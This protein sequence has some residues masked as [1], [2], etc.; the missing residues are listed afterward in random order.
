MRP[1]QRVSCVIHRGA[2]QDLYIDRVIARHSREIIGIRSFHLCSRKTAPRTCVPLVSLSDTCCQ[3]TETLLPIGRLV[4][5]RDTTPYS[6]DTQAVN[7]CVASTKR[8]CSGHGRQ[9]HAIGVGWAKGV[10]KLNSM[11]SP[12]TSLN[13]HAERTPGKAD[14]HVGIVR[15]PP[16]HHATIH[17]LATHI[18]TMGSVSGQS[19]GTC[20]MS[21]PYPADADA[22]ARVILGAIRR[23]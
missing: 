12:L 4:L 7:Q 23:Y 13:S 21:R 22:L 18:N 1:F 8:V 14:D 19:T 9:R 5:A 10:Q 3:P 17:N 15:S 11:L 20:S 2:P 16:R 6:W